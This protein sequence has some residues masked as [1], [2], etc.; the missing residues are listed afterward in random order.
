MSL[1]LV[2]MLLVV[3][4]L[5][6]GTLYVVFTKVKEITEIET[7]SKIKSKTTQSLLPF[8]SIADDVIDLGN[9]RYR[10]VVE[11]SSINYDLK[12]EAEKDIIEINFNRFI[13]SLTHPISFFIMTKKIDNTKI[14]EELKRDQEMM[15]KEYPVGYENIYEIMEQYYKGMSNIQN[16]TD[17]NIIKKKYII[18]PFNDNGTLTAF[19]KSEKRAECLK[20]LKNR[21][22]IICNEISGIS[23]IRAKR[24]TTD[25][26]LKMLYSY[27]HREEA[28]REEAIE[29]SEFLKLIVSGAENKYAEASQDELL[30]A[31]L[32]E[33]QYKLK[34]ELDKNKRAEINNVKNIN[35]ALKTINTLREKLIKN[36]T[37]GGGN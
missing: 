11:V 34:N 18:V 23:N 25:E 7:P 36:Q 17:N 20:Q 5:L 35:I 32:C 29:S 2:I 3:F 6:A 4:G 8:E 28:L 26:I 16:I 14:L 19:S 10:A 30:D 27:Y 15:K 33:T 22:Q 31:I 12:T 1:G 9:N 37:N 13:N 21:T 24:L